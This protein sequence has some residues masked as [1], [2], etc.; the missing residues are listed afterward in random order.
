MPQKRAAQNKAT[1]FLRLKRIATLVELAVHLHCS[2][3]TTQRRLAQC[4]AIHSYNHNA[5]YYTLPQIAQFDAHGLWRYRGVFFSRY[6]NLPQTFAQL[7]HQSPAGLTAAEA[8]ELLG[9]RP[10]SFL[11]SLRHHPAVK[12]AKHQGL[13]VSWAGDADRRAAQQ[14]QRAQAL[15]TRRGLTEA[16]AIALLVE[17]I[18]HPAASVE[19]LSRRLAGQNLRVAPERI[20]EFLAHHGVGVK[21]T[22]HLV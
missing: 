5:R 13:Y 19:A 9:L 16:E 22:P 6:G 12:R 4:R 11:W 15:S 14:R 1:G 10:S 21:K 8:G 18:K 2:A 20:G 17:K 3:R 7:V